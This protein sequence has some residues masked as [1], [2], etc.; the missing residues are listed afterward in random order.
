MFRSPYPLVAILI[1]LNGI[2]N[3]PYLDGYDKQPD[4]ERCGRDIA[5][6]SSIGYGLFG[7]EQVRVFGVGDELRLL[8][9]G[10]RRLFVR[11]ECGR[12]TF[13]DTCGVI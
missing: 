6:N 3:Q 7:N 12:Q 2:D 9:R 1:R 5:V 11:E 10:F 13:G 8:L 4:E